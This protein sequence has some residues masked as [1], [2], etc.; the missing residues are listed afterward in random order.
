[1]EKWIIF[2]SPS[3]GWEQYQRVV[4][5]Q[6][7]GNDKVRKTSTTTP[8]GCSVESHDSIVIKMCSWRPIWSYLHLC[9]SHKPYRGHKY[10]SNTSIYKY[11]L[12]DKFT[13]KI[14]M[15][16]CLYLSF[17]LS[18]ILV[19][20]QTIYL[21]IVY[22]LRNIWHAYHAQQEQQLSLSPLPVRVPVWPPPPCFPS[23]E[24]TKIRRQRKY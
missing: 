4:G 14:Y 6:H 13:I 1:M 7:L 11:I 22:A 9:L 21:S 16:V 5:P 2:W 15:S 24:D 23:P 3:F 10:Y 17:S 18:D 19:I 12:L 20:N 8:Q